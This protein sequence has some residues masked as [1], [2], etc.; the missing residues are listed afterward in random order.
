M[1]EPAKNLFVVGSKEGSENILE[2]IEK[3]RHSELVFGFCGAVGA[4]TSTIADKLE[5]NLIPY[6][7]QVIKI[8]IS[9]LLID[10]IPKY[11]K[12]IDFTGDDDQLKSNKNTRGKV[13]QDLGDF[14]RKKYGSGILAELVI[15]HIALERDAIYTKSGKILLQKSEDGTTEIS[16][17]PDIRIAWL[18]DSFKNPEEVE[19]FRHVYRNMFYLIGVLCP[20]DLRA[21]RLES[22]GVSRIDAAEMIERDQSEGSDSGQQLIKTIHLSD[23]FINNSHNNITNAEAELARILKIIFGANISPTKPEFAMYVAYSAALKSSCLSRQVGAAIV[24]VKGDIISIGCNDVP[25]TGGG[26]YCYEDQAEDCRC[27]NM[28]YSACSNDTGKKELKEQIQK[29]L[30]DAAFED[31][32]AEVCNSIKVIL[33]GLLKEGTESEIE[34]KIKQKMLENVADN[35]MKLAG[36]I[37]NETKIKQ[38][39]EYCRAVHAEMDAIVGAARNPNMGIAGADLYVTT[40]PCHNCARHIVAAGIKRVYYIEPYEKSFALRLHNDSISTDEKASN[41]VIFLP[42]QGVAPRQYQN[43]FSIHSDRKTSGKAKKIDI[44]V[45]KPIN[46]MF[47]D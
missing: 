38:L 17:D 42:F 28:W 13:L 6:D 16:I 8:K 19:V 21:Q 40:F 18:V 22:K 3:R 34:E 37:A 43:L 4:G 20:R 5:R 44:K 41:K 2:T 31:G 10:L 45:A 9:D 14:L 23:F 12:E 1:G 27:I 36:K 15:K 7:Y 11:K 25:K 30:N 29:Q 47:I 24:N 26:L 35:S 32:V 46:D 39:T 33:N